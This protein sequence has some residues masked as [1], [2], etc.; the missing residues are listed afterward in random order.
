MI[1]NET[2]TRLPYPPHPPQPSQH[3]HHHH[4]AHTYRPSVS[5]V[6]SPPAWVSPPS[7]PSFDP[8]IPSQRFRDEP[9]SHAQYAG[10]PHGGYQPHT[11]TWDGTTGPCSCPECVS[12]SSRSSM[13]SDY[14]Y[15]P[16]APPNYHHTGPPPASPQN[17]GGFRYYTPPPRPRPTAANTG[18]LYGIPEGYLPE[19]TG[20]E[21]HPNQYAYHNSTY[22]QPPM[23]CSNCGHHE[24]PPTATPRN[25]FTRLRPRPESTY[26]QDSSNGF[27]HPHY[28]NNTSSSTV[29]S[30]MQPHHPQSTPW[31]PQDITEAPIRTESPTPMSQRTMDGIE[32]HRV[33]EYPAHNQPMSMPD[34]SNYLPRGC[35]DLA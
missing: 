4:Q 5:Y 6:S 18:T 13:M 14:S 23:G 1:H 32:L 28:Q 35:S 9:T 16:Q 3:P 15:P 11:Q 7:Q 21:Y 26:T 24:A 27:P 22:G 33:S 20:P 34:P 30:S 19:T 10:T 2:T 17:A 12:R 31:L 29:R 8:H 25:T